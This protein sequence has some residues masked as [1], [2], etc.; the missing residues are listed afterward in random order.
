MLDVVNED[1][2]ARGEPP[3]AFE[4]DCRE[5]ICGSC[6]L[7]INGLA[8]G[9]RHATA[10]C[11]LFMREFEDG[12][13][14]TVEPWRADAF[15]IV[16]DLVTDRSA[17]DRVVQA[18]GYVSM[19]AGSAPDANAIPVPRA[20]ADA[21]FE[22]ATCIGCGACV[23]AC[24]NTSAMLFVGA[25]VAHFAELPQ[26]QPERLRR[27]AR[28]VETMDLEGFGGCSNHQECVAACPKEIP[29]RVIAQLNRD[30]LK[31]ASSPIARA[32]SSCRGR[33]R[34]RRTVRWPWPPRLEGPPASGSL[35]RR[36]AEKGRRRR[37]SGQVLNNGFAGSKAWHRS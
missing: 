7:V 37:H 18:G 4:H 32:T 16:R 17:F 24:P 20:S 30:Y 27:A 28:M 9:P 31:A 8:H 13:Q 33:A 26:G 19:K 2:V 14:I 29:F 3:I 11:Q 34:R 25:K 36:H 15:P 35:G 10:T 12:Q 5:G 6:S 23:A 22:A 21:A 1:L